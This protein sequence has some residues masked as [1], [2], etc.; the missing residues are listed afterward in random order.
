MSYYQELTASELADE[1]VGFARHGTM[2]GHASMLE[3]AV[4]GFWIVQPSVTLKDLMDAFHEAWR[5]LH[6]DT[7]REALDKARLAALDLAGVLRGLGEYRADLARREAALNARYADRN[8]PRSPMELYLEGGGDLSN[9]RVAALLEE[10]ERGW[11]R[12]H[13]DQS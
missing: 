13:A 8:R 11:S 6:R 9:P 10:A 3:E 5:A 12:H 2:T 4:L 7:S 1:L